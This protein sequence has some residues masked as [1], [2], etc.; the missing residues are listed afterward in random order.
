MA[1]RICS[2]ASGS[3]GNCIYIGSG[4]TSLL[5]DF[6]VSCRR[7]N[8]SLVRIGAG[9]VSDVFVTHTHSDH[10]RYLPDV[11]ERGATVHYNRVLH[12]GLCGRLKGGRDEFSGDVCVGDIT[13][14]AFPVSHDVPC[15]GYS[16]YSEGSKI[17]VV[18]D[19]GIMPKTTLEALADSDVVL[20]ESNYD[21]EMLKNN[22]CYPAYL[23]ARIAGTRGH[24]SNAECAECVAYLAGKGV[25]HIMLGHLSEQNNTPELALRTAK[26]ALVKYNLKGKVDLT[27][28]VQNEMSE[29]IEV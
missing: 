22:Y 1:L 19:L 5:L 23:K 26:E 9:G 28:A 14:S 15:F 10:I 6:G 16:F 17:T 27:V 25:G 3:K 12:G 20:I 8:G 21:P 4:R 24:L 2:I 7:V 11:S 13:V 18:T 29:V